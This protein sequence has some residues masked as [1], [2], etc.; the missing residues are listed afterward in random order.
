MDGG[1]VGEEGPRTPTPADLARIARSL[2]EFG[3]RYAVIGGFAMQHY[4]LARPTQDIDLLVD[5]DAANVERVRQALCVLADRA[6]LEVAPEDVAAYSVVR[7]A[8]EV[9]VDLLASACGVRY[10]DIAE[11]LEFGH[12]AGTTIPYAAP[13]DLLRTKDTIRPKD[14]VDRD[15]LER[16]IRP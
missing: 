7:V 4:G 1:T 14:A 16:L 11:R 13:E 3:A 5:P 15:F 2:N 8:D 9:V 6:A 12:T 10:A